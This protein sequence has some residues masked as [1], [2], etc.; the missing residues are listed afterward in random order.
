VISALYESGRIGNFHSGGGEGGRDSGIGH[1]KR[2]GAHNPGKKAFLRIFGGGRM[3]EL[4]R[5]K[6]KSR[7]AEGEKEVSKRGEISHTLFEKKDLRK[8]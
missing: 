2:R 5:G 3:Y 8:K 7:S 1:K 4:G 6:G